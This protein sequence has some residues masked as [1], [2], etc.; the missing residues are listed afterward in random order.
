MKVV[1]LAA[2]EGRRMNS[3]LPKPL[4]KVLGITL[5]ERV[6]L[7][8]K[9]CGL[10]DFIIV[11]GYKGEE[12]KNYLLKQKNLAHLNLTFLFNENWQKGNGTSLLTARHLLEGEFLL[13]MADHIFFPKV[14]KSFLALEKKEPRMAI[15]QNWQSLPNIR[16]ETKV[17]I[18]NGLVKDLG[19]ELKEFDG[20]DAGIFLLNDKVFLSDLF[21]PI[22]ERQEKGEDEISLSSIIRD[23]A[24]RERLEAFPIK[25]GYVVNVNTKISQKW[26]EKMIL[27]S[28]TKKSDGPIARLFN[29]RLSK[30]I[31]RALVSFPIHPNQISLFSFLLALFSGIS[32]FYS[33]GLGGILAQLSSIWDGVDG[34]VARIKFQ[35]T[36][37]G[38]Y[39]DS[40]L[41]RYGDSF[42]L[43]C[44]T[45]ALH[46]SSLP[47]NLLIWV[48]GFLAIIG[49]F[50]S[51]LTKDRFFVVKGKEYPKEE[52]RWLSYL[53]MTRD[54]RL[55]LVMLGGLT[56]QLFLT[57]ILI[58]I[59][60]NL[61]TIL[62]LLF[63]RE[64]LS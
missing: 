26:A 52:K 34:E 27:N 24:R 23:F 13:L 16:E 10:K 11:L 61:K 9:E 28:Q 54:F 35:K 18:E 49:S 5:M 17:K 50:M 56:N 36:S 1:V 62:R 42:I 59:I 2:G 8:A 15:I 37:Y 40:I 20:I 12:I 14:L 29:R 45:L 63:V 44:I 47:G 48:F 55:F 39:L 21:S 33:P 64:I 32:F 4:N 53:P 25:D 38:A 6:I 7:A 41:D 58:A 3:H 19:K 22:Y 60:T 43:L 46:L 30:Y 57:L 51:Q 31:T